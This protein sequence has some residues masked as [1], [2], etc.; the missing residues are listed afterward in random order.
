MNKK[1]LEYI[2]G[3]K[4]F[5]C[6]CVLL[7]HFISA[8]CNVLVTSLPER[9]LTGDWF[10]TW[11]GTTPLN[12]FYNGNFGVRV[13]FITSGFVLSYG[14]FRTKDENYL[15]KGA[16]KRYFRLVLPVVAVNVLTYLLM[17]LGL[18]YHQQAA[19][20][21]KSYDWLAAFNN[22]E[23]NFFGMLKEAFFGNFFG[24]SAEY[25]GPLWTMT[26]EMMGSLLVF[27]FLALFGKEKV[28]FVLYVLFLVLFRES[29]Y[30]HFVVGMALCDLMQGEY[31]FIKKYQSKKW[32]IAFTVL[33]GLVFST[34]PSGTDPSITIYRYFNLNP[35][36]D[37]VTVYHFIGATLLFI[38]ILNCEI[39]QKFFEMGFFAF[40]GKYCFGLYLLHWPIMMSLSSYIMVC[41]QGTMPYY[42][43]VLF[44]FLITMIFILLFAVFLSKTVEEWGMEL[45]NLVV[46]KAFSI[47]QKPC[48]KKTVTETAASRMRTE[49]AGEKKNE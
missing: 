30:S 3:Y 42:K 48:E 36:I 1:R 33:V 26:Y 39:L 44:N 18:L 46:Q 20:V 15:R 37:T 47:G 9:Q 6:L 12:I 49:G 45:S 24:N 8:F 22:F 41:Y 4:G 17:K 38:A 14:F 43:L 11:I 5:A 10:E 25:V 29:N 32:M 35:W 40:L 34:Y 23:P 28:R 7:S 31:D 21:C 27:A 2:E 13:F 19:M 16:I